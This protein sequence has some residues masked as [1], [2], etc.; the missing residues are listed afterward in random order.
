MKSIMKK[1]FRIIKTVK[2][3]LCFILCGVVFAFCSCE[4][5]F[6]YKRHPFGQPNTVWR[7]TDGAVEFTVPDNKYAGFGTIT[8]DGNTVEVYIVADTGSGMY[9][10]YKSVLDGDVIYTKDRIEKW[11]CSYKSKER[12]IAEVEETTY[13]EVGQKIEFTRSDVNS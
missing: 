1:R 8:K 9:V 3:L 11:Y 7:S 13:F 2:I 12:F 10:Y 4:N 6:I 5:P